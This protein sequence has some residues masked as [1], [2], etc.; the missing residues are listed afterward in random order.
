MLL[1]YDRIADRYD[2]LYG[3]E[4][5]SKYKI[6]LR[7]VSVEKAALLDAGCGTGLLIG[8]VKKD[9]EYYVGMDI[10]RNMLRK[11]VKR[12]KSLKVMYDLVMGDVELM[13]FRDMSFDVVMAFTV[14]H[15]ALR[16]TFE[17]KR[18][19]KQGGLLAVTLI[20]KKKELRNIVE[21][22]LFSGVR[23]K[24]VIDDQELKD[25]IYIAKL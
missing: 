14:V 20:R 6:V 15:E 11:A 13:P 7:N 19:I 22:Q 10:S 18:V 21:K 1:S 25:I 8:Y 5:E 24:I 16:L 9:V 17:A 2:E 4:Q 23:D 12:A 3:E